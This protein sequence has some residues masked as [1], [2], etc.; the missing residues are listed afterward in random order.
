[1]RSEIRTILGNKVADKASD[2]WG[3]NNEGEVRT[4]W[5][6]S[7]QPGFYFHGG[8]LATAGYYSKVLALQIKALEEG[9]Y[10]YGEF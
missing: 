4:M 3:Y 1:M 7:R 8:N 5:Q 6:D 10:R 9:I 2:V